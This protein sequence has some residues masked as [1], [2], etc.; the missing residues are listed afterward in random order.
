[1]RLTVIIRTLGVLFLLF[2]TTLL[3]P[4][5]ISLFYSDGEIQYFSITFAIALLVGLVLWFPFRTDSHAI[6]SRDGFLIVALMWSAMSLLGTVPFMLVLDM[7]FADAF[8][9]S[10]SGYTTT[11]ATVLVGLDAMPPSILFYRQEIQWLGGI[12]VIVLAVALL[13]ML[14]IGGMQLYKAETAGPLKDER[15]TPRLA[16]TARGLVVVYLVLTTACA[17]SFWLAGMS[18]FDAV[19]HSLSTVATAGYSTHDASLAF[20]DSVPIEFVA[21]VFMLIGAI[22]YNE[23]FIAWR[24][25]QLQRYGRDTQ[26]RAFV[27]LVAVAIALTTLV[28]FV[29]RTYETPAE[30]LRYAAFEVVSVFTTTGFGI[31]D[32]SL[33]P[34]ALPILLI[35][36]GLIGGCAGSSAGGIKVIRIVVLFKQVGIHIHRL[37]HP[38]AIRRMKVDGQPLPDG[39]V[40]AVGGFFAVYIVMFFIFMALAMM[41]GMDQVTAFGAV[42]ATISNLGPGLGD[43][44]IT[45]ADVSTQS[46]IMFAVAMLFGRLEIYTFLVLLTPAFWRR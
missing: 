12:G 13:P 38:M 29:T 14:G 20:F 10:A 46:K 2:S 35:F 34:L 18:L 6:R 28:L 1:M 27:L 44:A 33:W 8:F 4:I 30:A 42:A 45:F 26:T 41:D 36:T 31:A 32:F 21:T 9:E 22:S 15:F 40:E 23:H 3:P 37:I 25:L 39:V 11:G 24:T 17:V 43:V 19:A 7:S 16:R 5:G